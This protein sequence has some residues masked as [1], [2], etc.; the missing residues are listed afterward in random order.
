MRRLTHLLELCDGPA[1]RRE[2][3]QIERLAEVLRQPLA[4]LVACSRHSTLASLDGDFPLA[5]SQARLAGDIG[6]QASLPDAEAVLWGQLFAAW[7]ETEL[8][9]A[10]EEQME[11]ILRGL[12]ARS[13]LST[14]HAAALVLIEAEHGAWDQARG[15]FG[16][17]ATAGVAEMRPDMVYVW[18]LALLAHGC[19]MLGSRQHAM[20]L[21]QALLPFA[22]RVR[23]FFNQSHPYLTD[24]AAWVLDGDPG[25]PLPAVQLMPHPGR[26]SLSEGVV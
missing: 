7:L 12:V 23:Q 21:Y 25:A 14:A 9:D 1:A 10:D 19:C 5:V 4:R 13:H 24:D 22:D 6:K 2:L 17:L 11:Q 26:A 20:H 15:R 3:A 16:E 18:A 8:P